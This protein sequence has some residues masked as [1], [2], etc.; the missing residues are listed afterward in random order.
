MFHGLGPA[1]CYPLFKAMVN[2]SACLEE[3]TTLVKLHNKALSEILL[4]LE[5]ELKG[6][7]YSIADVYTFVCERIDNPSKYGASLPFL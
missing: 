3:L 1:G 6:F 4:K 2:T 5:S 7:K